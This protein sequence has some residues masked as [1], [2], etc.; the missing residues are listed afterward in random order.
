[1]QLPIE[2]ALR[3]YLHVRGYPGSPKSSVSRIPSPEMLWGFIGENDHQVIIAVRPSVPAC[4]RT[5]QVNPERV[6]D[7]GQP[8]DNLAQH[9]VVR[10]RRLE[11]PNPG[12]RHAHQSQFAT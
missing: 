10:R 9:R 7:L 6:I 4:C 5:E 2:I 12:F 3:P 8:P 11:G 1:M